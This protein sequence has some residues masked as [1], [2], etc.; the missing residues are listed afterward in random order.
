MFHNLTKLQT[1]TLLDCRIYF[2]DHSVTKDLRSLTGLALVFRDSLNILENYVEPLQSLKYL[3]LLQLQF[4]CSCENA[5]FTS[6]AVNN[7]Q[8]EVYLFNPS[9]EGLKCLANNGLDHLNFVNYAK[10]TCL[11]EVEFVLFTA[12]TLAL[13][14]FMAAVLFHRFASPYVFPLYYIVRGWLQG[15]WQRDKKRHYVYDTFVSYSGKDERWLGKDIV[16]NIT[17]SLYGSHHTLCLISRNYLRSNWCSLEMQLATYRLQVEH[18][19]VLILVFLEKI[20][21]HRLSAHHRLARLVKNRTYLDWPQDSEKQSLFWDRL[22]EKLK[23][24]ASE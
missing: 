13:L 19:D 3:H 6:W 22:W 17:D 21:S 23:P 4:Y 12:T 20:P 2:L 16:E 9:M 15:A 14:A 5:W 1:L 11:F 24:E 10:E 7:K 18:R 8:V